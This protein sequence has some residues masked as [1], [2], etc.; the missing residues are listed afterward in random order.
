MPS[1][2]I[3]SL[4]VCSIFVLSLAIAG[5]PFTAIASGVGLRH[6]TG[7]AAFSLYGG[8]KNRPNSKKRFLNQDSQFASISGQILTFRGTAISH[9]QVGL[10][11][12]D[13]DQWIFARTGPF[14]YYAF[15]DL[16]VSNFYVLV[17]IHKRYLFLDGSRTFTLEGDMF[18]VNFVASELE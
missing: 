17:V 12:A 9:A 18:N 6:E 3:A 15:H 13:L 11:N 2:K 10:Y 4:V 1:K 5:C 16:P 7:K 14:G 8:D